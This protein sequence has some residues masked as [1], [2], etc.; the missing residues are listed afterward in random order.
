MLEEKILFILLLLLY[1][2]LGLNAQSNDTKAYYIVLGD[3]FAR[4]ISDPGNNSSTI[5][6]YADALYEQLKATNPNLVLKKFAHGGQ[7][8][9]TL[10]SDQL[11]RVTNFMKLNSGLTKLITI[12]IGK[13][14]FKDCNNTS[15]CT[16]RLNEIVYNLNT[17]I[18]PMLKEAGGK[19]VQYG[20]TTNYNVYL[21]SNELDDSLIKVY[22]ENGVKVADMRNIITN[23]TACNYTYLCDYHNGHPNVNG[24]HAI[25]DVLYSNLTVPL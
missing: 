21:N 24:S 7:S 4:G 25:A 17:T 1:L 22:S 23:E 18:I 3:S 6:S 20:A 13:C 9:K 10:I 2:P 11:K 14:D 16:N 15:E 19:G 8:T 12:T 5:Y